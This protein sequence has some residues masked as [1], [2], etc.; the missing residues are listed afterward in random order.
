MKSINKPYVVK[1][2]YVFPFS[3]GILTQSL[4]SAGFNAEE[5]YEI[6]TEIQNN[7]IG[8]GIKR[9]GSENLKTIVSEYLGGKYGENLKEKY[10]KATSIRIGVVRGKTI[11]PYSKGLMSQSLKA[12]GI[13][14]SLSYDIARKI[15]NHLFN[16]GKNNITNDELR[17]ITYK[18]ITKQCG[19][20]FADRYLLWRSIKKLNKPFIVMFGG[21]T[22]AGKSTVSFE[23]AHRLGITAV[24]STDSIREI[25]RSMISEDLMPCIHKSSFTA[26]TCYRTPLPIGA[27]P[28]IIAFQ[29]QVAKISV[30]LMATIERAIKENASLVINGIHIVPGFIE[31][32]YFEEAHIAFMIVSLNDR[33]LHKE[34]FILRENQTLVKRKSEKYLDNFEN[35]RKLQDYII[36]QAKK[37][38]IPIIDNVD[39]DRTVSV[40]LDYLTEFIKDKIN[41]DVKTLLG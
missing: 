12:S 14:P 17:I 25:M 35:I 34:R 15:E 3:R 30:G 20:D 23:I 28:V 22:G 11:S 4:V 19:K 40:V 6:A 36:S 5:S 10:L 37:H 41:P 32:H 24:L 18:I 9:I 1:E 31:K 13:D 33:D 2:E 8:K 7:L 39:M 38:T 26:W 21:G 27:D 29:E 16:Q